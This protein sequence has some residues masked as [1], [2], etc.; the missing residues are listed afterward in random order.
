MHANKSFNR[1]PANHR[2]YH[3]LMEALVKDE[4][5][6]DNGV[7]DTIKDHKRK[8]YDD[9]EP[10][11]GS[12]QGKT[13]K[14]RKTKDLKSSKKPST[15]KETSKGKAPS[16]N[17]KTGK[18]AAIEKSVKEPIAEVEM[19]DLVNIEAEDVVFNVDQPHDNSTHAKDKVSKQDWF[20]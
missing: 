11:A 8:N 19:D 6:M 4:N 16:K 20:K 2:L 14:R 18:T 10:S 3:S 15:T 5:A 13:I 1:N 12:N 9:E 17:S 7:A